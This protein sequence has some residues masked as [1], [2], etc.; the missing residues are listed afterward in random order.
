MSGMDCCIRMILIK[1]REAAAPISQKSTDILQ[2]NLRAGTKQQALW[3]K[4]KV[5]QDSESTT[6]CR[7]GGKSAFT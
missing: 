2:Y 1:A 4:F 7:K 6:N 3:G 5:G